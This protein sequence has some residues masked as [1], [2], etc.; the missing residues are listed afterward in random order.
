MEQIISI[1]ELIGAWLLFGAPLL[2]SVTELYEELD[3][4]EKLVQKIN[5][6]NSRKTILNAI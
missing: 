4:R 5:D 1:I 2:Q 6:Y 3:K